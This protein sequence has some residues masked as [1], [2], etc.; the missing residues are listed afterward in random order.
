[1]RVHDWSGVPADVF[2]AFHTAW[3]THLSEALNGGILPAIYY[4][5]PEAHARHS[6]VPGTAPSQRTLAIRSVSEH[7]LIAITEILTPENKNSAKH[8]DLFA[9]RSRL[10]CGRKSMWCWLICFCPDAMIHKESMV[11]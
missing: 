3:I 5:S 1:M 10:P 6:F 8:M 7:R 9:A 11:R 4:A 2:H